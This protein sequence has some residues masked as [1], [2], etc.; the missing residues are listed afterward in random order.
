MDADRESLRAGPGIVGVIVVDED[1][2]RERRR[3]AGAAS[4]SGRWTNTCSVSTPLPGLSVS[5][6]KR[7][8]DSSF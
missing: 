1:R 4:R 3:L 6:A 7:T 8:S 2:Q 5:N